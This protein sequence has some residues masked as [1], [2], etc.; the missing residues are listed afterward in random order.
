MSTNDPGPSQDAGLL[1]PGGL[2]PPR[3]LSGR[4]G[5][6]DVSPSVES[7]RRPVKAVE[8]EDLAISATVFREGHD[9]LGVDA[10]FSDPDGE[11]WVVP[12]WQADGIDRWETTFRF[13]AQGDWSFAVQ[14]WH[15]PVVTWRHRA[16]I[17]VP[18]G[19]DVELEL[20]E[21][22]LTLERIAERLPDDSNHAAEILREAIAALRDTRRPG[23]ARL[24][25]ALAS[26]V[27]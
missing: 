22:A 14:A 6:T 1:R 19:V 26:D 23:E 3:T 8:G 12:M 18:A 25:V 15:D 4:F 10:V 21:G 9:A 27:E 24:A 2:I 5:I 20:E 11:T 17:K 16:E 7:G 13:L